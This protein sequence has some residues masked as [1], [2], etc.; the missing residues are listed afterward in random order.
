MLN[1][2]DTSTTVETYPGF[3]SNS[4]AIS[5]ELMAV[6]MEHSRIKTLRSTPSTPMRLVIRIPTTGER[7]SL[8][9]LDTAT[10]V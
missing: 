8:R 10:D 7:T 6:G 3:A 4:I 5:A 9:I 2:V 1:T